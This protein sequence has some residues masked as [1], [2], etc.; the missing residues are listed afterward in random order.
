MAFEKT[1]HFTIHM[2]VHTIE[3]LIHWHCTT[4][5]DALRTTGLRVVYAL[6]GLALV[7]A[8]DD[9]NMKLFSTFRRDRLHTKEV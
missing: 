4:S 5:V 7:G 3:R 6:R 9:M 8:C 2:A 1:N